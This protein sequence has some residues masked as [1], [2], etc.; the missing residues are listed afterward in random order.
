MTVPIEAVV[1]TTGWIACDAAEPCQRCGR[2]EPCPN[3]A[4][5]VYVNSGPSTHMWLRC[6]DHPVVLGAGR[7]VVRFVREAPA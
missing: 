1:R 5:A 2:R 7:E 3:Q 4:T 6:A